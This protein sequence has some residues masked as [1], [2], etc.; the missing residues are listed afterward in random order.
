VFDLPRSE[1]EDRLLIET[2]ALSFL[3][4]LFFYFTPDVPFARPRTS[5]QPFGFIPGSRVIVEVVDRKR[6]Q[7]GA[8]CGYARISRFPMEEEL[9][10]AKKIDVPSEVVYDIDHIFTK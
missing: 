2:S 10:V 8:L 6:L 5:S 1:H 7:F 4:H 3:G 9:Y